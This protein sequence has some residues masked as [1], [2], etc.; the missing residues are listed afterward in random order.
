M[1][2]R[3]AVMV[4]L[5][6]TLLLAACGP[7]TVFNVQTASVPF[8]LVLGAQADEVD[9]APMVQL[10]L[11]PITGY[12]RRPVTAV[13]PE[14]ATAGTTPPA[15]A[16]PTAT[17]VSIPVACPTLRPN[18]P[19]GA[20]APDLTGPPT[21]ATYAFRSVVD[22]T[23]GTA[24][25]TH[26]DGPSTL[27]VGA[28]TAPDQFGRYSFDVTA[29]V[30]GSTKTN[31][32]QVIPSDTTL[33]GATP[34]DVA[35]TVQQQTGQTLPVT[36]TLPSDPTLPG[37]YLDAQSTTSSAGTAAVVPI[38]IVHLPIAIGDA[39]MAVGMVG[40][41]TIQYTSTVVGL[42]KVDACGTAV[43]AYQVMITNGQETD[44]G[45][46]TPSF[47]YTQTLDVDT[48]HGGIIVADDLMSTGTQTSGGNTVLHET[49]TT[50]VVL[51]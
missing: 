1:T 27:A 46:S 13:G 10:P 18:A 47:T 30:D 33:P 42:T 40:T 24:P 2:V 22:Q 28:S 6:A 32:Y 34:P 5:P 8:G 7:T 21:V 20:V 36:V 25:A 19:T 44:A 35:G 29:S 16:A 4:L 51:R 12:P 15:S 38:P 37:I 48:T 26:Y 17:N 9:S 50:N 39:F 41:A 43:T 23:V 11:T 3:P 49:D 14:P 31:T 45:A